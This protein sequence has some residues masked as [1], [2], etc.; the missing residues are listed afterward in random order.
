[1]PYGQ[2]P[3]IVLWNEIAS[4]KLPETSLRAQLVVGD[5]ALLR[6]SS[7]TTRL[8]KFEDLLSIVVDRA[9][10]CD[11]HLALPKT[12]HTSYLDQVIVVIVLFVSIGLAIH[13]ANLNQIY[14]GA[15]GLFALLCVGILAAVP[16]DLTVSHSIQSLGEPCWLAARDCDGL[17]NRLALRCPARKSRLGWTVVLVETTESKPLKLT[18]FTEGSLAV[19]YALRDQWQPDR[20]RP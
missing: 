10:N 1:M 3:I 17:D 18:G 2:A 5:A 15:F 12:F 20:A 13:F 4:L 8:D 9:K 16:H 6:P 14:A 7:S 11:P 19:Y